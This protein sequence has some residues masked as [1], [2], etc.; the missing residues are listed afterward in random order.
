MKKIKMFQSHR[1]RKKL[2]SESRRRVRALRQAREKL[3]HDA[4]DAQLRRASSAST[5]N[6]EQEELEMRRRS[7]SVGAEVEVE[8]VRKAPIIVIST[9]C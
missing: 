4:F 8:T 6:V 3:H 1:K 9:D 5:N 2:R 7:S